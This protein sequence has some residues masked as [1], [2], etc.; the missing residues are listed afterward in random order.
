MAFLPGAA[1][2]P[3]FI[4]FFEVTGTPV[5]DDN[6]TPAGTDATHGF[7]TN[8]RCD[9]FVRGV[10][11]RPL[12]VARG[13]ALPDIAGDGDGR[14]MYMKWDLTGEDELEFEAGK[15][16]AFMVGMEAPA[17]LRGFTLANWN[18]ASSPAPPAMEGEMDRYGG[19]WGLRRE[20]NGETPPTMLPAE[21]PPGDPSLLE[22]LKSQSL[23][24]DFDTR[25][26]IAPTCEGYPDVDTYRDHEFYILR[27]E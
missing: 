2:A 24:P 6:N 7:S 26:A 13:G 4:Q 9:D 23:F 16:Y 8:H 14:L 19:G 12:H 18:N 5:I 20:G 25:V 15:R 27:A 3:V 11:Y 17:P 22:S 10:D 21:A 1:G